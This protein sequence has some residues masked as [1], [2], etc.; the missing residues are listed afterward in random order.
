MTTTPFQSRARLSP[1]II[2]GFIGSG[3][4][5]LVAANFVPVFISGM[6]QDLGFELGRAGLIATAMS[7]ASV[8]SMWTA[9]F[10]VA[11]RSRPLIA[12]VGLAF[13]ITGF[14]VAGLM[15]TAGS[16]TLGLVIAGLGCGAMGA[17][18]TAAVSATE[19]PDRSTTVVAMINRIAVSALFL[20]A[21]IYFGDLQQVFLMLAALGVAGTLLVRGLPNLPAG[22]AKCA[23][24][25]TAKGSRF[26]AVGLLLAIAFGAWSLT[27]DMVYSLTAAVFGVHAGLS[28]E[29]STALLAYKVL[30]GLLG[31]VLAP[32]ALKKLGRAGS[33]ATI[34]LISTISKF[35]MITTTNPTVYT[36]AL[37]VWGVVYLA[38]V[39]LVLG[40]AATMDVSGRVGV[41]VS[42]FYITGIACGPLVGGMLQPHVAFLDYAL[43][44]CI[45]A[46]VFGLVIFLIARN[47]DRTGKDR[48]TA[49][50]PL[51]AAL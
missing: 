16:V 14:G 48:S 26:H 22:L 8:L 40:L 2:G 51:T 21:P 33:I 4:I 31:T 7:L 49:T 5:S 23:A 30:G 44:D 28:V 38:V 1:K 3:V 25:S 36:V 27:E 46:L 18:S 20:L 13:M 39:V 50:E 12:L 17:A 24:R 42:S 43:L 41:L 45:P 10:F 9:N 11:R 15:Y 35:L 47:T 6:T 19:N 34:V 29:A 37:V 32:V